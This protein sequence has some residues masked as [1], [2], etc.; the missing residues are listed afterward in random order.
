MEKL[1][2]R[3]A[4]AVQFGL[5]AM[6][7]K[8]LMEK[9]EGYSGKEDPYKNLRSSWAV[10]VEPWRGVMVRCGDKVARREQYMYSDG[11]TELSDEQW[12]DPYFDH[13]NYIAIEAGLAIEDLEDE[14][15]L[16]MLYEE[17][18]DLIDIIRELGDPDMLGGGTTL[19]EPSYPP[20]DGFTSS[21]PIPEAVLEDDGAA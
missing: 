19:P 5:M 21:F 15:L 6:G 10:G 17:A 14:G 20:I 16:R 1:S 18:K 2:Q 3:D 12:A 9:R 7:L 11:A 4:I 8:R 13:T